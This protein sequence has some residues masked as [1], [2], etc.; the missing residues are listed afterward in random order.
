MRGQKQIWLLIAFFLFCLLP[1][2]YDNASVSDDEYPN[3]EQIVSVEGK[4]MREA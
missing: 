1:G 4:P 3:Y 2:G